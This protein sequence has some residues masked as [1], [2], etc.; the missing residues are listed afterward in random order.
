MYT[1]QRRLTN[2]RLFLHQYNSANWIQLLGNVTSLLVF[3]AS[4]AD[5]LISDCKIKCE[6]TVWEKFIKLNL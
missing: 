5:T 3:T 4:A 1:S 6:A 2:Y